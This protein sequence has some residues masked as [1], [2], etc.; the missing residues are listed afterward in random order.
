MTRKGGVGGGAAVFTEDQ[1]RRWAA[2]EET[3]FNDPELL[4]FARR[5]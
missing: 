2:A 1:K 5:V 3:Y 4:A